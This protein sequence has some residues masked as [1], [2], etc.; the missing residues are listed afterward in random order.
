MENHEKLEN[1]VPLPGATHDAFARLRK[2]RDHKQEK[3]KQSDND[4][5]E[6]VEVSEELPVQA[7]ENSIGIGGP[8]QGPDDEG[9][10]DC[11][12]EQGNFKT[13]P[14]V[15]AAGGPADLQRG[16]WWFY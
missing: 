3:R 10:H 14:L 11:L 9:R 4:N 13:V 16:K 5:V 8:D 2:R 15:K 7:A 1:S 12:A 6:G